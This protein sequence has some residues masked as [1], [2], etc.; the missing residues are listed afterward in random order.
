MII[1]RISEER[2]GS[3]VIHIIL[4]QADTIDRLAV[5]VSGAR[6]GGEISRIDFA[7]GICLATQR[8][9]RMCRGNSKRPKDYKVS[10]SWIF[11]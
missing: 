11:P 6:Y 5:D 10:V 3:A 4:S 2:G 9:F 7:P 1:S 8:R